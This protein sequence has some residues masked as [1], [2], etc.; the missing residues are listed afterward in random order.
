M[1]DSLAP[2]RA[3]TQRRAALEATGLRDWPQ[4]TALW[5]ALAAA[6]PADAE[7]QLR[8]AEALCFAQQP[9]EAARTAQQ[10]ARLAPRDPRPL[11]VLARA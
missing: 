3:D 10:A 9:A 4:A 7:C 1:N 2:P 11:V 5:Q 6:N 8:L